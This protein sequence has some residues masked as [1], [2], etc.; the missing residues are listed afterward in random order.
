MYLLKRHIGFLC[1]SVFF[2]TLPGTFVRIARAEHPLIEKV[3]AYQ[4]A[5][6]RGN[7]AAV[8]DFFS[9]DSR[10]WFEKK[11]GPGR[12]R[13]RDGGG[14]WADWDKFF[15]S[16]STYQD[17]SVEGSAVTVL[18]LETNDFYR[19]IDRPTIPVRL[20]YYFNTEGRAEG[21]LVASAKRD[22]DPKDRFDEFKEWAGRKRPHELKHLMPD[23]EIVPDL[24]RA[25]L[26]RK[27]LSEWR[28]DA[29]L[30]TVR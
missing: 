4:E 18:A 10:I 13:N 20:T 9:E 30:P 5:R 26:W 15:K 28:A 1:L 6:N 16:Q 12:I 25:K 14:P 7:E 17:Y 3:K 23:G 24:E 27:L 29:G 2:G 11:E 19:L 8:R 21:M 22:D